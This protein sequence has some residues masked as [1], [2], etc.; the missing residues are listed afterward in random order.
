VVQEKK[1]LSVDAHQICS[2]M[3]RKRMLRLLLK[4]VGQIQ[5]FGDEKLFTSV[6][7]EYHCKERY[8]AGLFATTLE[9]ALAYMVYL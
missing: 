2:K 4:V 9:D 8:L 7:D 3:A 5:F 6:A 1:L